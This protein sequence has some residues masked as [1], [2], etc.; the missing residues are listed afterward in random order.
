M[1]RPQAIVGVFIG[2]ARMRRFSTVLIAL[3]AALM[4][5]VVPAQAENVVRFTSD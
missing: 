2:H 3:V 5:F 4:G 1:K